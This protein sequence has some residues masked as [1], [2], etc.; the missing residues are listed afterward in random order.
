[1]ALALRPRHAAAGVVGAVLLRH[2]DLV[3]QTFLQQAGLW[4]GAGH[5]GAEAAAQA[6]YSAADAASL[7]AAA[8]AAAGEALTNWSGPPEGVSCP[9]APACTCSCPQLPECPPEADKDAREGVWH[10]AGGAVGHIVLVL[11]GRLCACRRR[12]GDRAQAPPSSPAGV[13]SDG[14]GSPG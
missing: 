1:M 13:A 2:A 12:D 5:A 7:A 8:A 3:Y 6:A 11:G 14:L 9:Q 4:Q 10:L